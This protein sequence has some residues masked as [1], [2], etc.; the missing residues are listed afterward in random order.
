MAIKSSYPKF[1]NGDKGVKVKSFKDFNEISMSDSFRLNAPQFKKLQEKK[2]AKENYTINKLGSDYEYVLNNDGSIDLFKK[3]AIE[4]DVKPTTIAI[5]TKKIPTT[6]TAKAKPEEKIVTDNRRW[7]TTGS[8]PAN[9]ITATQE[10]PAT[11]DTSDVP[12]LNVSQ[13]VNPNPGSNAKTKGDANNVSDKKEFDADEAMYQFRLL[14]EK[15]QTQKGYLSPHEKVI[16]EDLKNKIDSYRYMNEYEKEANIIDAGSTA[17]GGAAA[18]TATGAT[19]GAGAVAAPWIMMASNL[20]GGLWSDERRAR[21]ALERAFQNGEITREQ[22]EASG[23]DDFIMNNKLN[24][25]ITIGTSVLP[26]GKYAGKAGKYVYDVAEPLV[27]K[28]PS[29]LKWLGNQAKELATSKGA[30]VL[31]NTVAPVLQGYRNYYNSQDNA[32]YA[33]S[34]TDENVTNN[35]PTTPDKNREAY[36]RAGASNDYLLDGL[37]ILQYIQMASGGKKITNVKPTTTKTTPITDKSRLV[38]DNRNKRLLNPSK[39]DQKKS[40]YGINKNGG[41]MSTYA[42]GGS[43]PTYQQAGI[44][45]PK[46]VPSSLMT[47][48]NSKTNAITGSGFKETWN[49]ALLALENNPETKNYLDANNTYKSDKKSQE[50]Y[51]KFLT[52][53]Y[54][55]NGIPAERMPFTKDGNFSQVQELLGSQYDLGA[56]GQND[57]ST[58][59]GYDVNGKRSYQPGPKTLQ[60]FNDVAP[61]DFTNAQKPPIKSSLNKLPFMPSDLPTYDD[62]YLKDPTQ[63]NAIKVLGG[64]KPQVFTNDMATSSIPDP[65]LYVEDKTPLRQYKAVPRVQDILALFGGKKFK[66]KAEL[67]KPT[68]IGGIPPVADRFE[69]QRNLVAGF[70]NKTVGTSNANVYASNNTFNINKNKALQEVSD[71]GTTD[72]VNQ[73]A[74]RF[75]IDQG[76]R[77]YNAQSKQQADFSN[78]Q[79]FNQAMAGNVAQAVATDN[80]KN[81]YIAQLMNNYSQQKQ[82]ADNLNN[83]L[84]NQ[85]AMGSA[86]TELV[87]IDNE[88]YD[89]NKKIQSGVGTSWD[90]QRFNDLRL[91]KNSINKGLGS[92]VSPAEQGIAST[93]GLRSFKRGGSIAMQENNKNYRAQ[94]KGIQD[95]QKELIRTTKSLNKLVNSQRRIKSR[96]V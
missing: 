75:K 53:F 61:Y 43:I 25:A 15:K 54:T 36:S 4:T 91:R 87:K 6:T 26:V 94:L 93:Y 10:T 46:R 22:I 33:K 84:A 74:N 2:I 92:L 89:L 14:K 44:V 64:E 1:Q 52:D 66:A 24:T 19:A 34:L 23:Y 35:V 57:F 81:G 90:K 95:I 29:G 28:I 20:L 18:L 80:A 9:H 59:T 7:S 96:Y 47:L 16:Y 27:K 73:E 72:I 38:E 70:K 67:Y 63:T 21:A 39:I 62:N 78:V 3:K 55:K 82:Q 68:E 5:Q 65:N 31:T 30:Q 12:P 13:F 41:I 85:Q 49:A 45:A 11:A 50:Y 77:Q 17:F 88:L 8:S 48:P 71:K 37:R 32:D 40:E 60:P 86:S 79:N 42:K 51:T 56:T 83:S 76:N 58:S 69:K